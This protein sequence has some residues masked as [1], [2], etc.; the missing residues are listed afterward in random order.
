MDIKGVSV[1]LHIGS[2]KF[3]CRDWKRIRKT[4]LL[5]KAAVRATKA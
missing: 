1:L 5:P 4:D 2:N 3:D